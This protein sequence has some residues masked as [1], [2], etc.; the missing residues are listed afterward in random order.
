LLYYY[1]MLSEYILKTYLSYISVSSKASL[2][3][4]KFF[5]KAYAKILATY[6]KWEPLSI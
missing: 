5:L 2:T 6:C 4:W 3:F 1:F